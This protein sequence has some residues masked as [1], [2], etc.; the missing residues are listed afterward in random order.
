MVNN[1]VRKVTP[2]GVVS[3][4]AGKAP[5]RGMVD[6]TGAAARFTDGAHDLTFDGK[7]TLYMVQEGKVRKVT[8]AGVATTLNL[9]EKDAGQNPISYFAGGMAY[10]GSL[11]GVANGV[12]YLVDENGSMRA[13]AGSPTAPRQTDGPGAQAGF[14]KICGVT[15]DGAGNFYLLDC[16]EHRA[17]P[18]DVYPDWLE[19]HVRKVTPAGVVTT[20]Y[21]VPHD[22]LSRQPWH[23]AA[24]RQGNVFAAPTDGTVVRIGAGG[25]ATVIPGDLPYQSWLAVDGGGNLFV[26]SRYTLPAIVEQFGLDGK[27]QLIA[28]RHDQ[29]GVLTG[30]LPGSLNMLSGI[31]VDDQGTI[32]VLTENAVVRIVR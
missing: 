20:V 29:V 18:S 9:P 1:A 15:R 21:A 17:A 3:T 28:G 23:I 19:N 12:V 24:D 30:A 6:G 16:Y 14:D 31:A 8:R 22:D 5:Q 32:Y 7:D 13:L 10:Q 2:G 26:A 11:V 27:V 25:G 4:V